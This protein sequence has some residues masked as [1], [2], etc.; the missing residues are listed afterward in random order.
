[1]VMQ[2]F[3]VPSRHTWVNKKIGP[4]KLA[5]SEIHQCT[6]LEMLIARISFQERNCYGLSACKTKTDN[7]ISS[8]CL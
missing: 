3:M 2:F 5:F 8:P 1:M 6:D 7:K 4:D